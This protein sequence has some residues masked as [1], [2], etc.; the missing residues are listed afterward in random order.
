ME[1]RENRS[2][3]SPGTGTGSRNTVKS[4]YHKLV[5]LFIPFLLMVALSCSEQD[6]GLL[7]TQL[8]QVKDTAIIVMQTEAPPLQ[9]QLAEAAQTALAEGKKAAGTQLKRLEETEVARLKTEVATR[10]FGATDTPIPPAEKPVLDYFALGDSIASG[11]GLGDKGEA[12]RRSY[13]SYPY[14]VA[15]SQS[16]S[17]YYMVRF[18]DS[19]FLACSGATAVSNASCSGDNRYKCFQNQFD[20]MLALLQDDRP[21][22]VSITIG[23]NDFNWTDI[24]S[25]ARHLSDTLDVYMEWANGVSAGVADVLRANLG[26][27]L[28]QHPNVTVVITTVHNPFNRKSY[29]FLAPINSITCNDRWFTASCYEKTER[30]VDSLNHAI[31][32]N[33]WAKLGRPDRMRIA[34]INTAFHNHASDCGF[35]RVA[36]TWIQSPGDAS[37]NSFPIVPDW[38][39]NQVVDLL[40]WKGDCFH[41]NEKGAQAYADA[42]IKAFLK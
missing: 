2:Q 25:T 41:P 39:R 38:L 1:K 24:D 35:A 27:L 36:E 11:H 13:L 40:I 7:E 28:E 6:Q 10:L 32:V 12:C 33:V 18:P 3:S 9:T 14:K 16:L 4:R 22:L 31:V 34:S 37:F 23:A 42:V 15:L 26:P 5:W 30:G 20:D 17:P 8:A 29:F 21:T 19:H